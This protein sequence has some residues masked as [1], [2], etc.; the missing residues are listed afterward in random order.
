[1]DALLGKSLSHYRIV[2]KIAAG[3]M[4]GLYR[5]RDTRL[6]RDVAIKVILPQIA[7]D[8]EKIKR[9]EFEARAA[10]ALHH[11]NICAIYDQ[12]TYQGAPFL[13][14]ELLQGETLRQKLSKGPVPLRRAI[15]YAAQ[16]VHGLGA[17]H[18]HGL[19]HMDL[20][21]ENLFI[22][23]DDQVKVLDFGVARL[24]GTV[25]EARE[26][27]DT[28]TDFALES[29]WGTAGYM[30]PEQAQGLPVDHRSDFFSIGS[31]LYEMLTGRRAFRGTSLFD[32]LHAIVNDE[33]TPPSSFGFV[34]PPALSLIGRRCLEKSPELRFQ[35]A[36]D[37]AFALETLSILPAWMA[38]RGAAGSVQGW[39][40]RDVLLPAAAAIVAA[41]V[42]VAG[43]VYLHPGGP[44][45]PARL[46]FTQ[47]TIERGRPGAAFFAPDGRSVLFDASWRGRPAGIYETGPGF[48]PSRPVG[49]PPNT[50]IQSVSRTGM[51]AVLLGQME[52]TGFTSG[53]TPPATL[54]EVPMAGGTPR[55]IL[56]GVWFSDWT[57]D[58][59]TLAVV[60][61]VA[62]RWRIEMPI[63]RVLYESPGALRHVRV[64]PSGRHLTFQEDLGG[65]G[66]IRGRLVIIDS[67]GRIVAR[68]DRHGSHVPAW[69]PDGH[70]V[71]F[72]CEQEGASQEWGGAD[73]RALSM[74]GR[75]RLIARFHGWFA[76][77][78]V[79][80]D[81]RALFVRMSWAGGIRG[82]QATDHQDRE[83]GWYDSP[84]AYDI[85]S[86]GRRLLFGEEAIFGG[87]ENAVCIRG[88]DG[89]APTRLGEGRACALSPD[90][91]WA[92]AIREGPPARL[93]LYPTGT[94]VAVSLPPGPI[95]AY[96]RARWMPDG[97]RVCFGGAEQG[98]GERAYVQEI[99][100]GDPKPV[101][102]EGIVVS[103]VSPDGRQLAYFDARDNGLYLRPLGG[104]SARFVA[105]LLPGEG[106]GFRGELL[107]RWSADGRSVYI[108][109]GGTS[110]RVSR[111]DLA[112]GARTPWKRFGLVD[113]AGLRV[114]NFA[115]TPDG[116]SYVFSYMRHL[117]ELYLVEGLK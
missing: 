4:G 9:F 78:D 22:T 105:K 109:E 68:S 55:P 47:L 16:A 98:R 57:P 72:T 29:I 35:S 34:I 49:V 50:A 110:M 95:V 89:S 23:K 56:D 104:D 20:K 37:L 42:A 2:E 62:G 21:P 69:S 99:S 117:G 19:V 65:Q 33:P 108:G 97:R 17:A 107:L 94:G 90:G 13:V 24:A 5:A 83:L 6:A 59:K 25:R 36:R 28:P 48:Y 8:P 45:D 91:A 32:T 1:M 86:D 80:R 31:I 11:P 30:S 115:A 43:W 10:G 87:R 113:P 67:S 3:A 26:E 58:G 71:W 93:V 46:K 61:A 79:A 40:R 75:E 12:G 38:G 66:A 88:M 102:P 51:M 27:E 63:G 81:G 70:E 112:T 64:S 103:G 73:L 14:M 85:S 60:H 53:I 41:S 15:D 44:V 100:G 101:A 7:R 54:A 18:E 106:P 76:L 74:N 82:R 52:A 111:I 114:V 77:R 116:G 92:L 96:F 39:S 84:V